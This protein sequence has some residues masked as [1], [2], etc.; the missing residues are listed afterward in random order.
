MGVKEQFELGWRG[1]SSSP[2]SFGFVY[3]QVSSVA[4]TAASRP[5]FDAADGRF[6]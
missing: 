2:L 4:G 5:G 3:A 1:K 6:L